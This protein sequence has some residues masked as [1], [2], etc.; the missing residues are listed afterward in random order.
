MEQL[1]LE[2]AKNIQ[3]WMVELRR[4]FHKHPELSY[5]EYRTSKI[6]KA[7]LKKLGIEVIPIG[8]TGVVGII[9]GKEDGPVIGLRADMDALPVTE[10]TGL[11]Y[12]S[13]NKGV[14]HACGHDAHTSMLLG[15]AKILSEMKDEFKGTVKLIF[16]PAEEDGS[17]AQTM[18]DRGA[19]NNPDVDVIVGMHVFTD[20]PHGKVVIQEGP[21]MASGDQFRIEIIGKQCHGSAPWQG[22]DAN[23]C[24]AAII[25]GVQTLVSRVNDARSP[26]VVNMGTVDGG[27][28]F[29]ITS[30]KVVLEGANRTFSQETREK[31]PKW[32]ENMVKG[33]CYAYGCEYK[34]EYMYRC[35]V[36]NNDV[37]LTRK[38]KESI[39]KV[40]GKENV[41]ATE[42]IMGSEDFSM[43][44][45]K[46][47][48]TF[49][50][51]GA[52]SEEKGCIYPLHSEHF[53]F[54]EDVLSTG[55]AS[56]AKAALAYLQ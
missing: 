17:G 41:L 53:N 15:A 10:A 5:K 4:D 51:L 16:Q 2:K 46:I 13:E 49:M 1:T 14:M 6:V 44:Q 42:K 52:G 32:I 34:F 23:V 3:E 47:K 19:L 39:E 21:L 56:Y 24:A 54:D 20:F 27:E 38:I 11:P 31:L 37:A 12:A 29:N 48:G 35:A 45:L 50:L 26:I 8:E 7:E 18:I 40:I 33:I 43:Y 30:G 28:R 36:T 22:V 9:N 55:A 25:Q